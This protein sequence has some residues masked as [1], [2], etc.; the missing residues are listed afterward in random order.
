MVDFVNTRLDRYQIQER[1]GTGGMARV[2]KAWDTNLDRLVAVKILHDH[3]AD[4]PNFKERF[5]REAKFIA[6]LN[7]PEHCP[8]L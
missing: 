8:D 5:E 3:L 6:S 1:I 7:H 4:D 2:F